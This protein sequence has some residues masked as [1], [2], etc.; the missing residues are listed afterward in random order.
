MPPF[1]IT[2][3]DD[4]GMYPSSFVV[5]EA[6]SP[7]AI[8]QHMLAAPARWEAFLWRAYE[9]QAPHTVPPAR[10]LWELVSTQ[11]VTPE[12]LLE[13]LGQTRIDGDSTVQV[14]LWELTVQPLAAVETDPWQRGLYRSATSR[15][16]PTSAAP[17]TTDVETPEAPETL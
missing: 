6:P 10:T 4:E 11:A 16:P 9:H 8:A 12:A 3:L 5:V 2:C 17:T 7:L 13:L 14:H 15:E 1:L